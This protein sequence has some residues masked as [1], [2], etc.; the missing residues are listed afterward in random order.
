MP[1]HR[2]CPGDGLERLEH[3]RSYIRV[4][5]DDFPLFLRKG[6]ELLQDFVCHPE[7]TQIV[8]GRSVH[9]PLQFFF[10]Q[11]EFHPDQPR[12]A[13]DLEC[14]IGGVVIL[15]GYG[16]DQDG[17]DLASFFPSRRQVLL[18]SASEI[19]LV[20]IRHSRPVLLNACILAYD[21]SSCVALVRARC[22]VTTAVQIAR[23]QRFREPIH[24][25]AWNW[26]SPK[27]AKTE[28]S[29][30]RGEFIRNSSPIA[31]VVALITLRLCCSPR[32]LVRR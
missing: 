19:E 27:F 17:G 14:V 20:E 25:S 15:W 9:E 28:F 16:I 26:N 1:D 10:V 8:Q 7:L 23:E 13:G 21:P 32:P 12:E 22:L 5:F 6:T 3:P 24:W 29:E 31:R 18:G 2:E 11:A 4:T 30:V